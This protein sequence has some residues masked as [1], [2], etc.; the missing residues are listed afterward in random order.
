VDYGEGCEL[1][2]D[3][4]LDVATDLVPVRTGHLC[5][6]LSA[7]YD[8][9]SCECYTHCDYAQYVE[10]GTCYQFAQPYFEP[11]LG[12]AYLEAKPA[13]DEA[14]EEALEEEEMLLQMMKQG[15]GG[16]GG[17]GFGSF[18]ELL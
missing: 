1:F 6:S 5:D 17:G 10:Y 3:T 13:W 11:A 2:C 12:M 16:G 7:E 18:G 8:D 15:A 14:W 9:A 4:F